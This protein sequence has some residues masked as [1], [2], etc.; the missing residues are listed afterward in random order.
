MEERGYV[1]RRK[2]SAGEDEY[3]PVHVFTVEEYR[4]GLR[5]GDRLSLR[6]KLPGDGPARE[7]GGVWTVLTGSPQDPEALWLREPDGRLHAWDDD[8]TIFGSSRPSRT[9]NSALERPA[10]RIRSP[11]PLTASVSQSSVVP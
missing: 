3:I 2:N 9:P 4:C 1:L 11:R 5:A 10:G 7:I 8:D 6:R